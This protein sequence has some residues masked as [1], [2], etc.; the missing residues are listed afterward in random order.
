MR[1]I[2]KN[3][4]Q[5]FGYDILHL[6]TDPVLRQQIDLFQKYGVNLVFDVGANTG[7]Y[8]K[9][10]RKMGYTGRIVSFEP[11][12]DAFQKIKKNAQQDGDWTVVHTAI[13]DVFGEIAINVAQNSYSSSILDVLPIH[14]A[15][16]PES[17]SMYKI[18]V[19]I[20]TVDSLIDHYYGENSRLYVKIDTQ[21]YEKQVFDG[22][23]QSLDKISGF[24]M[25]LSLLPLYEGETLMFDMVNLLRDHGFKLMLLEGGHRNYDTGEILQAE[26]Y[27]FRDQFHYA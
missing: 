15:S 21:G 2:L 27:F 10:L 23:L 5:Q 19:P 22:C 14:V 17:I 11:L 16:A 13:G 25:E 9:R 7:Q 8:G 24:Q 12:P 4:A 3:I 18:N 1:K 6:P 20:Q 26:G